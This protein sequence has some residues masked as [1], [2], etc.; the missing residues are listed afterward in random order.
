MPLK[1][2]LAATVAVLTLV[3]AGAGS[4][5]FVYVLGRNLLAATDMTLR[6][7]AEP[8]LITVADAQG[9]QPDFPDPAADL[10][11]LRL[12]EVFGPGGQLAYASPAGLAP[13]LSPAGRRG[14][15]TQTIARMVGGE[16]FR[17][18]VSETPGPGGRWVVVVGASL[19]PRAQ[20]LARVRTEL[21]VA[22]AAT[23]LLATLGAWLIGR[24]ALVPVE[25]MRR[26]AAGISVHGDGGCIA[27]PNG[28]DELAALGNTLNQMLD[29]MQGALV[30]QRQLVADA[31][32][33]LRTPLAVLRTELELAARPGRGERDLRSAI[34]AA[35]I[36]ADRLAGLAEA[37]L[38]LAGRDERGV[39]LARKSTSLAA[40]LE[41]VERSW[42]A[43]ANSVGA[44]L[45]STADEGWIE[46]DP[47][48]LRQA[49]DN[50][51]A[52]A[53]RVLPPNGRV[54]M[55]GRIGATEVDVEVIDSG[56]GFPPAFLPHAFERFSRPD[57]ARS[58]EAGGA[59][60]GLS[61]VAAIAEAHGGRAEA[62]NLPGGGAA[63]RMQFPRAGHAGV[64]GR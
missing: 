23:V 13:L 44:A 41:G 33:E 64:N 8:L 54:S 24:A 34:A 30:R 60:L 32:H 62:R 5:L 10:A 56:P 61:I 47:D 25:R 9:S 63:V 37:L 28:R 35:A 4:V 43:K 57:D 51:L 21:L 52:N 29:R 27:V 3:L 31:G 26:S 12:T 14:A 22:S 46:V 45:T 53:L 40:L 7:R 6:A 2:R 42:L 18:L 38:L 55:Q 17:L 49:L 19:A 1:R 39:A 59:G 36:E 16:S 48:R 15:R 58:A 11:G 20:A 50:L